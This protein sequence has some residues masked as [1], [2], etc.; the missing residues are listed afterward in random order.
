MKGPRLELHILD[1][2]IPTPEP[3]SF[4]SG[5]VLGEKGREAYDYNTNRK[6]R[7]IH[8]AIILSD[9]EK[10]AVSY[11]YEK[12]KFRSVVTSD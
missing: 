10:S 9:F 1:S 5:L 6:F 12:G 11:I 2:G 7:Y 8:D 3:V 4:S